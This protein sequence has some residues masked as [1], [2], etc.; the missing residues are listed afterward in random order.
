MAQGKDD[1][2]KR[3]GLLALLMMSAKKRQDDAAKNGKA[4]KK[5]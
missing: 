5:D 3:T 1:G 4:P 2:R